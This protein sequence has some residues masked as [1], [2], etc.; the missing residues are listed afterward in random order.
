[1]HYVVTEDNGHQRMM[2]DAERDK[3]T[4]QIEETGDKKSIKKLH[5]FEKKLEYNTNEP[6]YTASE[7][8]IGFRRGNTN[9]K[10]TLD[11]DG[12]A[13]YTAMQNGKL[14]PATP[15][16]IKMLKEHASDKMPKS[17]T[18]VQS[19]AAKASGLSDDAKLMN[20]VLA[21]EATEKFATEKL[22]LD[23]KSLKIGVATDA[24]GNVQ[25][26]VAVS[27]NGA[28]YQK[29]GNTTYAVLNEHKQIEAYTITN[30]QSQKMDLQSTA[31]FVGALPKDK[32]DANSDFGKAINNT[33][34]TASRAQSMQRA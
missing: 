27:N 11:E 23:E 1:M 34:A 19:E 10:M 31:K 5:K 15:E 25:A 18:S 16:E 30:G 28:L 6:Q 3:I 9:I 13:Q 29:G 17:G 33:V 24:N 26:S 2:T 14:R 22:G 4:K 8:E 12:R 21:S 20:R 32:I 7:N